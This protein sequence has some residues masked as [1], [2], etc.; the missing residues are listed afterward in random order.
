MLPYQK[1]DWH[2]S[3]IKS[4]HESQ[5]KADYFFSLINHWL[6]SICHVQFI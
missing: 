6:T 2:T 5:N 1:L 4:R 3:K